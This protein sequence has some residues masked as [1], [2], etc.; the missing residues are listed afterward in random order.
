MDPIAPLDPIP[1]SAIEAARERIRDAAVRTPCL[2]VEVPDA[3]CRLWLKLENLQ[4]IGAFK[5]RGAANAMAMAGAE[6]LERGVYTTSTGN[7]AQGVAWNARR[8]GVRCDVVVPDT[9]PPV[10]R[11]AIEAL[12]AHLHPVPFEEWWQALE[13][14]GHPDFDGVY[15]HPAT[16]PH[17]IAGNGTAGLEILDDVPDVRA[18][19]VP[20][21]GGGLSTGVASAIKASRADVRVYA[22]EVD[23]AAP[24]AASLEAGRPVRVDRTPSFVD[25][26]GGQALLPEVW[27]L[28]S[29]LL[30]GSLVMTLE[31][32]CEGIRIALRHARVLA[33]GAGGAAVAAALTGAAGDGDV[34]AVIS[35]GNLDPTDLSAILR[36]EVP[37]G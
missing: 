33:E 9:A 8:L 20:Y 18:V 12:G 24:F 34:V 22:C 14:H 10:K 37:A 31:E 32:I 17:V 30:D 4:P 15:V 6:A 21:G 25:G 16:D 7:M 19:I 28:A 2:R 1:L 3:P 26:M 5:I 36:G 27:G 11:R 29:T 23:T 13:Q 35:G